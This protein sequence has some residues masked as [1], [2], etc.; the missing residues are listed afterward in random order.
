M[1]TKCGGLSLVYYRGISGRGGRQC[2]ALTLLGW[3]CTF[4]ALIRRRG[5]ILTRQRE[6]RAAW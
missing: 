6:R 1:I 2:A 5:L 3:R 4:S